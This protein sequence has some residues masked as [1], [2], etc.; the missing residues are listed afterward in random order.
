MTSQ[1]QADAYLEAWQLLRLQG[2]AAN[3][4]VPIIDTL[5]EIERA[6]Q[7]NCDTM[8]HLIA[9]RELDR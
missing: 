5:C 7:G 4:R 8:S 3:L 9:P 1:Q 2:V 6:R